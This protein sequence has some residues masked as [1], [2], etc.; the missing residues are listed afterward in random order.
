MRT[1]R[2]AAIISSRKTKSK[3]ITRVKTQSVETKAQIVKFYLI[4]HNTNTPNAKVQSTLLINMIVYESFF[5]GG[6]GSPNGPSEYS[7]ALVANLDKIMK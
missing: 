7:K 5:F 6:S 1:P 2:I 4:V 3:E